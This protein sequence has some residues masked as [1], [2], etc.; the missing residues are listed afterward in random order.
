MQM[1]WCVVG[2]HVVP[3][4]TF[5]RPGSGLEST[6]I[7]NP[8][9]FEGLDQEDED[10][11]EDTRSRASSVTS[12][13]LSR[14]DSFG[15]GMSMSP[16]GRSRPQSPAPVRELDTTDPLIAFDKEQNLPEAPALS[17]QDWQYLKDFQ[18]RLEK[19]VILTH[20]TRCKETWFNNNVVA[21]ICK[22]CRTSR[23]KAKKDD[24][25]FLMSIENSMDPGRAAPPHLPKLTEV[26][27]LLIARVHVI[28][29][30]HQIRGAQYRYSGHVCNFL[31][32]VG[33]VYNKLPILPKDLEIVLLKP[34]KQQL[35]LA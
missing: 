18:A 17:D 14:P 29:E 35:T 1:M 4:N 13:Q 23:D 3:R 34:A 15:S 19:E 6:E 5:T 22:K 21:G 27:E 16:Q 31:R 24:E 25:P 28:V 10:S 9:Y 30:V 32:D 12:F 20:C 26:E 7:C 33:K 8:C 11:E 2:E